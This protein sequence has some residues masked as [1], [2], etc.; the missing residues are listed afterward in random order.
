M[1]SYDTTSSQLRRGR[2]SAFQFWAC[3]LPQATWEVSSSAWWIRKSW[4]WASSIV[5]LQLGWHS[6]INWGHWRSGTWMEW[7]NKGSRW[8][9]RQRVRWRSTWNT[10]PHLMEFWSK[11][12]RLSAG[13]CG[14]MGCWDFD[15]NSG[16]GYWWFLWIMVDVL[17]YVNSARSDNLCSIRGLHGILIKVS[18]ILHGMD[19]EKDVW[20]LSL[21]RISAMYCTFTQRRS[22]CTAWS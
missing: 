15:N 7:R 4:A 3:L 20:I 22:Q 11:F 10:S 2:K 14:W 5:M 21:H 16:T 1:S 12:K 9:R 13:R 18:N 19:S 8:I 6:N 17:D